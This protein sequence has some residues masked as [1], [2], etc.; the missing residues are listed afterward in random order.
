MVMGLSQVH[1]RLP[2][3][4]IKYIQEKIKKKKEKDLFYLTTLNMSIRFLFSLKLRYIKWKKNCML[5]VTQLRHDI[6][7]NDQKKGASA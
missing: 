1:L 3:S 5:V 2:S 6:E 7:F 4:H